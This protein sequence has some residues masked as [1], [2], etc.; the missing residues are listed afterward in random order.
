D[1]GHPGKLLRSDL[2]APWLLARRAGQRLAAEQ[3][4]DGAVLERLPTSP[5][6][7]LGFG[8][9]DPLVIV[10]ASGRDL[11]FGHQ[12]QLQ[13]HDVRNI[14]FEAE[15]HSSSSAKKSQCARA[16]TAASKA[17]SLEAPWARAA[18]TTP[19]MSSDAYDRSSSTDSIPSAS[20]I[21]SV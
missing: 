21:T 17:C 8:L 6:T 12:G 5:P 4:G 20:K 9:L 18:A 11:F 16:A 15:A 19:M 2:L 10:R 1:F 14:V 7:A 3:R 13:A